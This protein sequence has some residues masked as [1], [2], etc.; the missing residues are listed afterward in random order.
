MEELAHKMALEQ[1]DRE[2]GGGPGPARE[3]TAKPKRKRNP[4]SV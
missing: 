4:G 2:V 1:F 3:I